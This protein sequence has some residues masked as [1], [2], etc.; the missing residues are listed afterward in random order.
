MKRTI[1]LI[2]AALMLASSMTACG[3]T[4]GKTEPDETNP[5]ETNAPATDAP[6][7][8]APDTNSPETDPVETEAPTPSYD[9]SLITENG[10][11]KAHIVLLDGA[12]DFEKTAADE[13]ALHIKLVSGADV[14]VTNAALDDSLPII[15]ATPDSLP[16]L[17]TLFPEDLAWLRLLAEE[18]NEKGI[19]RR[20]G[21][22]GFAI[23]QANGKIYI[24]GA[25]AIGAMNGVYDF[26][27]ENMDV[28]WIGNTDDGIIYDEMPTINVV[29]A[30]Y[31]E[32]SPF[33]L[34]WVDGNFFRRNKIYPHTHP[35]GGDANVKSLILDSP[36][37]DPNVT[38]YWD[39]N[40]L[41]EHVSAEQSKQINFWSPLTAEVIAARVIQHLGEF[42]EEDRPQ[43]YNVCMEDIYD[44]SVYPAMTEPFEYAPGQFVDPGDSAYM[45]T[46]YFT[47]INRVA[48]IVGNQYP[49]VYINTLAYMWATQSPKCELEE[50]VSVWF[51]PYNE[52]YTQDSFAVAL[53]EAEAGT[54]TTLAS[55]EAKY[56]E[57]WIND[58]PATPML[59]YNYYMIHYVL[60]WYERPIWHRLSDNF[61]YYAE[62]GVIG[63]Y[64]CGHPAEGS[65]TVYKWT[66]AA[67]GGDADAIT[68]TYGDGWSMNLLTMWILYKLQWNPY[69]DVDALI[70]EFC[71]KVYGDAA[72]YMKE[73][74][75]LLEIGWNYGAEIIPYEFNAKIT[76]T[77]DA[78][79]YFMYFMDFEL[80]DGTYYLDAVTEALTKA[81]E[82]ADDKTKEFIRYPY[83]VFSGGWERFVE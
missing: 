42:S 30:D 20:Y 49:D 48:K 6:E 53:A 51:C 7:T 74:Y 65:S 10:V 17:E 78:E 81:W 14:T 39:T 63:H 11:A 47:F 27:E 34:S 66:E 29:K 75:D 41:G 80:E 15:I 44:P 33:S 54:S 70:D 62:T 16:E 25:N 56:Y 76:I 5:V 38:E 57:E 58:H 64:T 12:S 8:D 13:L 45:S 36:L 32:K 35:Y 46:V 37:Y 61:H 18:P 2:L 43:Y 77:R 24:F 69:E 19:I 26:I 60:G 52:D 9:T 40:G 68:F 23:R 73:Y 79:Y 3:N 82:A 22:D 67:R 72:P 31:R 83:E 21:D 55:L 50:N 71:D 1:S 28:I 59:I 4:A